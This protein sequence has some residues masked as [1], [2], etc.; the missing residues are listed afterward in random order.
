MVPSGLEQVF[1]A[2]AAGALALAIII[3]HLYVMKCRWPIVGQK[4]P[5]LDALLSPLAGKTSGSSEPASPEGEGGSTSIQGKGKRKHSHDVEAARQTPSEGE[6]RE[7]SAT[8]VIQSMVALAAILALYGFGLIVQDLTD[9]LTD[10]DAHHVRS[11]RI[12]PVR[13]PGV[14]LESE[15]ELRFSAL[16]AEQPGAEHGKFRL[17]PLGREL[18]CERRHQ[19]RPLLTDPSKAGLEFLCDPEGYLE[20]ESDSLLAGDTAPRKAV[21]SVCNGI[22]YAAKNWC[23]TENT[24][25]DELE[26][27]QRR[28]D[29]SRSVFL[30]S[31][32]GVLGMIL[33]AVVMIVWERLARWVQKPS[34]DV[35]KPSSQRTS[36]ACWLAVK[37]GVI[38]LVVAIFARL[39]Y[40]HGEGVFNERAYGYYATFIRGQQEKSSPDNATLWQRTSAEYEAIC[41][42][43]YRLASEK[44]A[45]AIKEQRAKDPNVQL[46]VVMDLDETVLDNSDFALFLAAYGETYSDGRWEH[47]IDTHS[48]DV[49]AV[50]GVRDFLD[51]M[52]KE[53]VAVFFV[54][55]RPQSSIRETFATL[56]RLQLTPP[57]VTSLHMFQSNLLL[58]RNGTSSSKATRFKTVSDRHKVI[59]YF[60]DNLADFPE[61][62][63]SGAC[64]SYL[65]RRQRVEG[66]LPRLGTKWFFLPN[67]EYGDWRRVLQTEQVQELVKA[68]REHTP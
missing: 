18:L 25:Y 9:Y 6:R 7:S 38:L 47:W 26:R 45:T 54:S 5:W 60:G 31:A 59:G 21:T 58:R 66:Y 64:Q 52:A 33:L 27:I 15:G 10:T 32:W 28:I 46:A 17:T 22:Y 48:H 12:D 53:R 63:E 42:S 51:R 56:Q 19:V 68:A 57:D 4:L 30:V 1:G 13:W 23:Y 39:G 41:R 16:V 49:K 67:A 11:W 36:R 3:A 20:R 14:G 40:H 8:A 2:L 24:L 43:I 50:P 34:P 35:A 29:F 37:V 55:N 62:S 65:E 61:E 44:M